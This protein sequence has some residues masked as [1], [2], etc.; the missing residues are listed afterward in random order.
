MTD[1]NEEGAKVY[2]THKSHSVTHK[3]STAIY[4]KW[5][6]VQ[7]GQWSRFNTRLLQ[8][9]NR[10]RAT[11]QNPYAYSVNMFAPVKY[12]RSSRNVTLFNTEESNGCFYLVS[13]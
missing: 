10:N 3:K 11:S 7:E 6:N 2:T 5:E 9:T 4:W 1:R 12:V 13:K 8:M